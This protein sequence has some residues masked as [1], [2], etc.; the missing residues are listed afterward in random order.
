MSFSENL[1]EAMFLKN[2]T[3]RTLSNLTGI[4]LNTINSYLKSK[5]SLPKID[6]AVEIAA[7]LDVSAEFLVNGFEKHKNQPVFSAEDCILL[8]NFKSLSE[9]EQ[10][11]VFTLIE[12]L[13]KS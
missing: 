3:A 12:S 10:K 1:K 5:N 9:R 2:M 4:N 7:V 11:A 8:K 6:K 13:K